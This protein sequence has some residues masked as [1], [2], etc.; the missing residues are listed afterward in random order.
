[1]ST[2][3]ESRNE[4]ET[5]QDKKST[6]EEIQELRHALELQTATQAGVDATQVATTAGAQATQAAAHA[7]TWSTMVAG[8]AGLVVGMFVALALVATT[9]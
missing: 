6:R 1:M 8:S 9:R 5:K 3:T 4:N 2:M 7:G